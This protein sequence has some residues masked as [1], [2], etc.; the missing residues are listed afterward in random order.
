VIPL[1]LAWKLRLQPNAGGQ[2]ENHQRR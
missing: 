1:K 2:H